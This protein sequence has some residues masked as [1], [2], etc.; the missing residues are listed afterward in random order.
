MKTLVAASSLAFSALMAMPAQAGVIPFGIQTNVSAATISSWGWTECSR[1]ASTGNASTGQVLGACTGD[2]VAMGIWDASLGAYGA[3][4]IGA[5]NVVTAITYA[6]YSGDDNGTVQNW[7]NGLNW[8]RTSGTGSWGFT[9]SHQTMLNSADVY[10]W[11]GLNN[12]NSNMPETE[13]AAGLSFH[14]D[15]AGDFH[16]G[17]GYNPDGNHWTSISEAGDQRVF[18][19]TNAV[20][21]AVPEPGTLAILGL[22]MAALGLGR[23]HKIA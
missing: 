5:K 17:W 3:V 10:L 12:F 11:N 7:S 1:S 21:N 13:L 18:W 8:Y 19:T 6:N 15:L 4:G 9:T 20:S 16:N 2:Y 23:R 14:L 22:G